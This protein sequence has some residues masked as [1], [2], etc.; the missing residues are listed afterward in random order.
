MAIEY[1]CKGS[2]IIQARDF[3]DEKLGPGTFERYMRQYGTETT[4]IFLPGGWYEVDALN[5]IL[6]DV[7]KQL[8]RSVEDLVIEISRLNAR[9]DLTTIY[10]VFLRIAAPVRVLSFTPQLWRNYVA[11]GEANVLTNEPGHYIVENSGIPA[12]LLDWACG[13]SR[14]FLPAAVELAGGKNAKSAIVQRGSD[15]ANPEM[16]RFQCEVYYGI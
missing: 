4:K 2:H 12:R 10:R 14:G 3:I 8:G 11:F 15:P 13:A 9:R 1:K 5:T 7:S 16:R 6:Q